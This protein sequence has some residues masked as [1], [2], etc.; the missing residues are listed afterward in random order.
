MRTPHA[1]SPSCDATLVA[2]RAGLAYGLTRW[3]M[4][5]VVLKRFTEGTA[6]MTLDGS[7]QAEIYLKGNASVTMLS[8][9][10]PSGRR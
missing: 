10:L 4:E 2:L 7:D 1:W 9:L 3:K 8:S 5:I 6:Q